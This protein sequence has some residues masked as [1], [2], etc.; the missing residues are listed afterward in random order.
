MDGVILGDHVSIG[1]HVEIG[2][3][4]VIGQG[5]RI[6]KGVFLP[7]NSSIGDEVFIGPNVTFCDDKYPRVANRDYNAQ[8]PYVGDRASIGAG[9]VILP[10]V[11]IGA[12]AMLGAG[13]VIT[14]DVPAN[15]LIYGEPA[16]VK[17]TLET[18]PNLSRPDLA[19][20]VKVES[21]DELQSH[22]RK[23]QS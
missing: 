14:S 19:T 23:S 12:G 6:G 1:S 20:A 10:G 8:P 7:S 21:A 2:R 4:S 16:R 9:C 18:F 17:R 11:K 22:E 5:T 13:S 15:A 3:G